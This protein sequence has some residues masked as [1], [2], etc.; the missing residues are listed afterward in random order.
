[1]RVKCTC[2]LLVHFLVL[3]W[4]SQVVDGGS[5]GAAQRYLEAQ[6]GWFA[7]PI[8]F[9]D[10]PAS[11]RAVLGER[12]PAFSEEDRR[13]LVG[14]WDFFGQNFYNAFYVS[15]ATAY[16][17]N[18][19][20]TPFWSRDLGIVSSGWNPHTGRQ[21]G[22]RGESMWLFETP[23]GIRNLLIWVHERYLATRDGK[24]LPLYITENGCSAPGES[25]MALPGV[26]DDRFRVA[27][28]FEYITE[29]A[30][31]VQQVSL[32]GASSDGSFVRGYF[33]WSL[34]DNFEWGDGYHMRFGL[35]YVDFASAQRP[36]YPKSSAIWYSK[37]LNAFRGT[38][39]SSEYAEEG[40]VEQPPSV[41]AVTSV[42]MPS[43]LLVAAAIAVVVLL[44]TATLSKAIKNLHTKTMQSSKISAQRTLS[45][46]CSVS[47]RSVELAAIG[48]KVRGDTALNTTLRVQE[49][50]SVHFSVSPRHKYEAI[51]D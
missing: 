45:K 44:G 4:R 3:L 26:L 17:L 23:G 32:G 43:S 20:L 36:R 14:S 24:T 38:N 15:D 11:M 49:A 50:L 30:A 27:F 34:L 42:A 2:H 6:L 16:E 48:V 39:P 13:L 37:L 46:A 33:A 5:D 8:A 41:R 19:P 47:T 31:A 18:D 22:L 25:E 7:D 29:V 28:Y 9:G 21:I 40:T 51:V 10:Y 35:H 1:M 12:L